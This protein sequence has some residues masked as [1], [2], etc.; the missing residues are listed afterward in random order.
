MSSLNKREEGEGGRGGER[1][2][3]IEFMIR[4]KKCAAC[5]IVESGAAITLG[6]IWLLQQLNLRI[7]H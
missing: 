4:L 7:R 2:R 5:I 6:G 1:D 3:D